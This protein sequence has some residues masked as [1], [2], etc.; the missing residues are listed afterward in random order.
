MRIKK[1]QE[2]W[3]GIDEDKQKRLVRGGPRTLGVPKGLKKLT[4]WVIH[5]WYIQIRWNCIWWC[6]LYMV[7]TMG[8][9][10]CVWRMMIKNNMWTLMH[11]TDRQI[12]EM[13]NSLKL[14]SYQQIYE[15]GLQ[16]YYPTH[17]R[18]YL[19]LFLENLWPVN[20]MT[21]WCINWSCSLKMLRVNYHIRQ[22][23]LTQHSLL[24]KQH[25]E[26]MNL[27]AQLFNMMHVSP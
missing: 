2:I 9:F 18:W 5:S 4:S 26:V 22:L 15:G 21:L 3:A 19:V 10:I 13:S 23:L 6:Q 27:T 1:D 25:L 7:L 16:I 11:Y 20:W 24:E 14:L 8:M 17:L 12:K